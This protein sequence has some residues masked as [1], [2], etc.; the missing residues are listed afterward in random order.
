M[1]WMLEHS[2]N[3]SKLFCKVK[4]TQHKTKADILQDNLLRKP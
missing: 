3:F 2:Y 1:I 4:P